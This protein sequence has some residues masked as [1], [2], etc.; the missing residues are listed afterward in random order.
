MT[1]RRSIK[2]WCF[3]LQEVLHKCGSNTN[4]WHFL[5]LDDKMIHWMDLFKAHFKFLREKKKKN[6]RYQEG[7]I[8]IVLDFMEHS[9]IPTMMLMINHSFHMLIPIKF[10]CLHHLLSCSGQNFTMC[11]PQL[12]YLPHN[13]QA[14]LWA[15]HL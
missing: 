10:W 13:P 1:P 14:C 9:Q 8:S 11:C 15:M 7:E 2:D 5:P 12:Q 4:R 6:Y 3:G